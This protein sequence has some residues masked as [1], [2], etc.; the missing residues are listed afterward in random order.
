[1]PSR[2]WLVTGA[3]IALVL[4]AVAG[5][6]VARQGSTTT[7]R[8]D[9]YRSLATSDCEPAVLPAGQAYPSGEP[10]PLSPVWCYQL[11]PMPTTRVSGPNTWL[12]EFETGRDMGRFDDGDMDYRVFPDI[13]NTDVDNQGP[14]R[15]RVFV[16]QNHW[17]VDT[18]AGGNGGVLIRPNRS[19]RFEN[20]RLVVEADVAAA[21]PAYSDSASAEID[22]STAL[23]PTG[24]VVDTQYGY[25]LFGGRWT[26]GC[27]FQADRQITCSLFNPSGTPGDPAVFGNEQG[28]VWQ[29]LPFQHVGQVNVGGEP[30][31]EAAAN[32]RQCGLNQM[33]LFCRDRFRLE[34]ARDS[35]KVFVNG[36][37]Y[38]EQSGLDPKYQLPDEFLGSEAYVYF[39]SWTN[40]PL[41]PAYRFHWDR[42]AVNPT[43]AAGGEL[44][45]SAAPSFGMKAPMS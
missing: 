2:R 38:F 1:V 6:L 15:S 28:R 12:D 29:M 19:F 8:R 43:D 32:F 35:V 37:L 22:I 34:L 40:R 44:A 31:G 17:M 24:R 45:P 16:N 5:T 20:G 30:T 26:F 21:I 4:V 39:T 41:E 36:R 27:R 14:R 13:D 9:P 11:A 33:D 10:E 42:L 25:G 7:S 3:V 18:A 23:E